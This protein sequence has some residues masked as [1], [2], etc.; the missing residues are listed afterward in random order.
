MKRLFRR[1][2]GK[3]PRQEPQRGSSDQ[4]EGDEHQDRDLVPDLSV[5]ETSSSYDLEPVLEPLSSERSQGDALDSD[6]FPNR[7]AGL[8]IKRSKAAEEIQRW[9]LALEDA[10]RAI[11]LDPLSPLAYERKEAVQFAKTEYDCS[12]VR[13][14][15]ERQNAIRESIKEAIKD[16]PPML[17][18]TQ[19][20][21]GCNREQ[22]ELAFEDLSPFKE[23]LS[24]DTTTPQ[25]RKS[26]VAEMKK[27][28]R[29]VML[30]HAWEGETSVFDIIGARSL[31]D[32]SSESL[33]YIEKLQRFCDVVREAG[34]YW[35]WTDTS[36]ISVEAHGSVV[37][38]PRSLFNWY[39][40][41][42]RTIVLLRGMRDPSLPVSVKNSVWITRSWTIYEYVAA[43]FIW[44][45]TDD[46]KP[47]RDLG[48]SNH[49]YSP[50]VVAEIHEVTKVSPESMHKLHPGVTDVREKLQLAA[51]RHVTKPE[52]AAYSL[53]PLFDIPM[54][55][56]YGEG[57]ANAVGRLLEQVITRSGDVVVLDWIGNPGA[58]NS[59]L[60]VNL[61][62]YNTA[63]YHV[64][65]P[66]LVDI[67]AYFPELDTGSIMLYK[68]LV[69]LESPQMTDKRLRLPCIT[70]RV[71]LQVVEAG[72]YRMKM[73]G[74]RDVE[75]RTMDDIS[76][77]SK[78]LLLVHPWI[79]ALLSSSTLPSADSETVEGDNSDERTKAL[80]LAARLRQDFGA[81]LL[82][83]TS[84]KEYKRV[85]ADASIR[86]QVLEETSF[87]RLLESIR[88][89]DVV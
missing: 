85:A 70:F 64:P 36:C 75:I 68:R 52:D 87:A 42:W 21:R 48:T 10:N 20:G 35:A 89:L 12:V 72:V 65:S 7:L 22:Q 50:I 14:R 39:R 4:T 1:A 8:Y 83:K 51:P 23:Y 33:Y 69:A 88:I 67:P 76:M 6:P 44:F 31:Y 18:N 40:Y 19:T 80:Q 25:I 73:R 82:R 3:M 5:N 62:P 13:T 28:C 60:P 30:S 66:V 86:V 32:L 41:A 15:V 61:R 53:C 84:P 9:D 38:E 37:E 16:W 77:V 55:P 63:Q 54:Q 47:Y 29:Y 27:Y 34:C 81:L 58:Y 74:L 56:K 71:E 43:R 24:S 26:L 78:D 59:C 57:T 79:R 17:I 11:Q 45:Y 2:R 46:W 49:K